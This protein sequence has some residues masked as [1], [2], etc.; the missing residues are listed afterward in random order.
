MARVVIAGNGVT[1]KA[2]SSLFYTD[3][4]RMF[5]IDFDRENLSYHLKSSSF[6]ILCLPSPTVNGKQD[7]SAID[8]WLGMIKTDAPSIS[9]IIRSTI[10]PGTTDKLSK[11]YGLNIAHV[12]EFLTES[13]A[14]EDALNPEFLV[15][16]ARDILLKEKVTQLFINNSMMLTKKVIKC[17]P[18]TAELIKYSMNSFFALKV[19][20]ANQLWD[21]AKEVGA[22]YDQ[23]REVL[24][25]HKWG[26][27]NGWNVWHNQKRGFGGN[28]LPK[29]IEAFA[30]KFDLP[31][32]DTMQ[33][34]NKELIKKSK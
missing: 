22:N 20:M 18:T 26:S 4:V 11:L 3:G 19:T 7:L 14:L 2:T 31:L 10:L 27:K 23:V 8:K 16:G 28:C 21:V 9:V 15:V 24:E 33:E 34:I 30:G 25:S 5:D 17:S 6:V 32:I 13:T 1:G 12:P 29:D